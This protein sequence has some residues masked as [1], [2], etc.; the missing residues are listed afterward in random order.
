[1]DSLRP[2]SSINPYKDEI[3]N[4]QDIVLYSDSISSNLRNEEVCLNLQ[5]KLS[6]ALRE[7]TEN[8]IEIG[9]GS[10]IHL[11]KLAKLNP[12]SLCLGLELRYKRTI[13]TAQKAR[14]ED[15][16]NIRLIRA[17]AKLVFISVFPDRIFD[18]VYL[19]FPDPWEKQKTKKH[20]VLSHQF[21]PEILRTLKK[22][23]TFHFKTDHQEY[24]SS[25]LQLL[26][27]IPSVTIEHAVEG[28]DANQYEN[29]QTEFEKLFRNQN[30][31]IYSI[32]VRKL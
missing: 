15:L 32:C 28:L 12:Q 10:G 19:N 17:D 2:A 13:K 6:I 31:T 22:G 3:S 9:S 25:S 5:E 29:I 16:P 14:S 18:R 30:K 11:S 1:M 21:F 7:Y 27:E 8:F 4:Y 26:K 24:Y 20:R 23:A